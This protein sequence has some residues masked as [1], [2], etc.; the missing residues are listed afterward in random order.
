MKINLTEIYAGLKAWRHE[1]GIT[2]QSQKQGYIVNIMEELGELAQALRDF[3]KIKENG[4]AIKTGTFKITSKLGEIIVGEAVVLDA[5]IQVEAETALKEAEHKIIDALCDI[6][7]FTINAGAVIP[8]DDKLEVIDTTEFWNKLTY[9]DLLKDIGEFGRVCEDGLFFNEI[10]SDCCKLCMDFNYNF[11]IAMLEAIKE[12][13]SRKGSYDE[14]AKKWVKDTSDEA[15]AKWY[16]ANYE[17]AR[18]KK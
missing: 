11:E 2:A 13:N 15:R 9:V 3:E 17:L 1:R 6:A 14:R 5:T 18:I 10:L 16:K 12:I 4:K 7:V 8:Y